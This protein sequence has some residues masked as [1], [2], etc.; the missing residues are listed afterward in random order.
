MR[1]WVQAIA[2]A[3]CPCGTLGPAFRRFGVD[4]ALGDFNIAMMV[5]NDRALAKLHFAPPCAPQVNDDEARLLALFDASA[6]GAHDAA[7]RM[8]GQFVRDD[9]VA[10]LTTAAARTAAAIAN[11][12]EQAD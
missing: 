11:A 2:A 5:L 6:C 1:Q 3:R 12:S 7:A 10:N 9:A 8:A 4:E